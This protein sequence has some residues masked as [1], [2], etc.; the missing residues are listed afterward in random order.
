MADSIYLD[1]AFER[2]EEP[3]YVHMI[4]NFMYGEPL[5]AFYVITIEEFETWEIQGALMTSPID[6]SGPFL[7]IEFARESFDAPL[8]KFIPLAKPS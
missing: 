2:Y 8:C 7:T 3:G 5:F 1:P 6:V 4:V